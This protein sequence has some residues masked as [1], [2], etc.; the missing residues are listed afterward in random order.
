[1]GLYRST[2]SHHSSEFPG[3][4]LSRASSV[5]LVRDAGFPKRALSIE[6]STSLTPV[7]WTVH[8]PYLNDKVENDAI[9]M[10]YSPVTD[11]HG[12]LM[13]IGLLGLTAAKALGRPADGNLPMTEQL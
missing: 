9:G 8:S 2:N 11:R 6:T 13:G 5:A 12:N 10:G 3:S 1:L 7:L 4:T